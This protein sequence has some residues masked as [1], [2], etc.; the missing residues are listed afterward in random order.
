M[1][2]RKRIPAGAAAGTGR[3]R[4]AS[5]GTSGSATLVPVVQ[6]GVFA[7]AARTMESAHPA[8]ARRTAHLDPGPPTHRAPSPPGPLVGA[9]RASAA[10]AAAPC[11]MHSQGQLLINLKG[12]YKD[13]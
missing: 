10:M 13:L 11:Y 3:P 1:C 6:Y 12:F 2:V 8:R 4:S 5:A 9:G 7:W